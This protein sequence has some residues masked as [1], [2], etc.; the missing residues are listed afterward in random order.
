MESAK[1]RLYES[2]MGLVL[3]LF[4]LFL[5]NISLI[6]L[7]GVFAIRIE[8]HGAFYGILYWANASALVVARYFDIRFFNGFTLEGAKATRD[9][10]NR[11][12]RYVTLF[13]VLLFGVALF[14]RYIVVLGTRPLSHLAWG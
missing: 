8:V 14:L 6:Y 13:S 12:L 5:G 4:W 7:A 1:F 10:W 11:Y 3:S 2:L 9:D